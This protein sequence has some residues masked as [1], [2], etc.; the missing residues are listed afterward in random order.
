[1]DPF[2]PLKHVPASLTAL[3]QTGR[4]LIK[5]GTAMG[6]LIPVVAPLVPLAFFFAWL[7]RTTAIVCHVPVISAF[8]VLLAS[9]AI[10][11]YLYHYSRFAKTEPDRLQSE[12]YRLE[13]RRMQYVAAK[14]LDEP[15]P[16]DALANATDNPLIEDDRNSPGTPS[17][18]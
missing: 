18:P 11:H 12:H 15:L 16:P 9:V 1:M 10:G 5:R 17:H 14:D 8:L 3:L 7:F 13:T 2:Q 6:P 4:T